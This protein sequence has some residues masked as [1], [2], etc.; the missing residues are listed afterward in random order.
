MTIATY[1]AALNDLIAD[2]EPLPH[3]TRCSNHGTR[4]DGRPCPHCTDG[5]PDPVLAE[6]DDPHEEARIRAA[7]GW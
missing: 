5:V 2:G 7:G 4:D 1:L 6:E 3:C